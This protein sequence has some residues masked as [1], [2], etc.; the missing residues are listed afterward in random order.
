M[1]EYLFKGQANEANPIFVLF[2]YSVVTQIV[3]FILIVAGAS[4]RPFVLDV[5]KVV[6]VELCVVNVFTLSAFSLYFF[7]ISTPVGAA[8]K[9]SY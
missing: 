9:F 4:S 2:I 1:S 8:L 6:I 5:S 3:A 7:A